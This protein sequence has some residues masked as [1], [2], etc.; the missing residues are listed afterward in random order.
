MKKYY[1]ILITLFYITNI[2][3]GEDSMNENIDKNI[4]SDSKTESV[5]LFLDGAQIKKTST[6]NMNEGENTFVFTKLPATINPESIQITGSVNYKIISIDHK[7]NYLETSTNPK[8]VDDLQKQL[9]ETI[10]EI[11]IVESEINLLSAEWEIIMANKEFNKT[12]YLSPDEMKESMDFFK[13]YMTEISDK[14]LEANKKKEA[15]EKKYKSLA[16]E[17]RGNESVKNAVSEITIELFASTSGDN[18]IVLEYYVNGSSWKPIYDIRVEDDSDKASINLKAKINQNTGEDWENVSLILSTANPTIGMKEPTLYPWRLRFEIDQV[19]N[20]NR[21]M[22]DNVYYEES[23]EMEVVESL[24]STSSKKSKSYTQEN[25]TS[26]EF[27]LNGKVNILS[28]RDKT[29]DV[30]SYELDVEFEY[31]SIRKLDMDVFL[32]ASLTG[33]ENI[34]LLASDVNVFLSGAFVGKTYINPNDIKDKLDISLGRD[35]QIIV[36][37]EK[38]TEFK[39]KTTFG[40]NV[41]ESRGFD[42]TIKNLKDKAINI[43]VVDQIPIST[44][45]TIVVTI[46]EISGASLDAATGEVIWDLTIDSGQSV[47]KQLKYTVTYPTGKK[48]SLE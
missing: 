36:T 37:R 39:K 23:I 28:S 7:I 18:E 5:T 47:S 13:K 15:L 44:D 10:D 35:K 19:L 17:L 40:A 6:I 43:E 11:K 21:Y 1:L 29:I 9:D 48:V 30:A 27:I 2:A 3:F 25:R 16:N 45:N 46:D 31:Y 33:W 20:E 24:P 41:K 22:E 14:S 4:I 38:N 42:I 12:S 34:N 8:R 26:V 32:L